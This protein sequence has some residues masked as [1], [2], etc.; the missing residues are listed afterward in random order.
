MTTC[1]VLYSNTVQKLS[2]GIK[3]LQTGW[4]ILAKIS[5]SVADNDEIAGNT[6]QQKKLMC[7]CLTSK[8]QN[9][10]EFNWRDRVFSK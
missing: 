7:V 3:N 2:E 1:N 10:H 9:P 8:E 5:A 4:K 6:Q